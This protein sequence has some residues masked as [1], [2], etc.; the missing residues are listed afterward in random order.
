MDGFPHQEIRAATEEKGVGAFSPSRTEEGPGKPVELE[1]PQKGLVSFL[2]EA[3]PREY[4][5]DHGG[6]AVAFVFLFVAVVA[7]AE[8]LVVLSRA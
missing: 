1:L 7:V 2:L 8:F 4:L 3:V 6:L 5:E